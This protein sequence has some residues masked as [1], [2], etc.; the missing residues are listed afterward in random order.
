M[1]VKDL[2]N[3]YPT[4]RIELVCKEDGLDGSKGF[5]AWSTNQDLIANHG[6]M[7]VIWFHH[8]IKYKG[9]YLARTPENWIVAGVGY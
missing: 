6:D 8:E 2:V 9:S 1:K 5:I 3:Q 7:N 4:E